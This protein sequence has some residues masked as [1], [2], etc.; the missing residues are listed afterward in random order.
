MSSPLRAI[1]RVKLVTSD[2]TL[3]DWHATAFFTLLVA[4]RV[5]A[6]TPDVR[7]VFSFVEVYPD[8]SVQLAGSFHV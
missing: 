3:R 8:G 7:V 4:L 6:I 5:A 2:T 1:S